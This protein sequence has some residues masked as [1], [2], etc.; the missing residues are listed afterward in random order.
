MLK[1]REAGTLGWVWCPRAAV[2]SGLRAGRRE[3]ALLLAAGAEW[4]A[5]RRAAAGCG[6][7]S[8]EG[9]AVSQENRN[10][11][12]LSNSAPPISRLK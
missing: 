9:F 6:A 5:L 11:V 7:E 1:R 10:T 8:P 12:S 2:G 4:R 3:L